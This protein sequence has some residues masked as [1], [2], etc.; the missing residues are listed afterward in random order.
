MNTRKIGDL[1]EN[2]VKYELGNMRKTQGS[3]SVKQ[4]GDLKDNETL[5]IECKYRNKKNLSIQKE[6]IDKVKKQAILSDREWAI[7]NQLDDKSIYVTID[8]EFFKDL[9]RLLN[10]SKDSLPSVGNRPI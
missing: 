8:F 7:V 3:G 5:V 9:Y 4:D 2:L 10:A 1:L 6:W